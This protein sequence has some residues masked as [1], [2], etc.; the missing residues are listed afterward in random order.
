MSIEDWLSIDVKTCS[1]QELVLLI[2]QL[3][4]SEH[5]ALRMEIQRELINRLRF[6]GESD[7]R[8]IEILL[9]G[10][11]VGAKRDKIAAGWAEAFGLTAREFKRIARGN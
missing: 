10:V 1:P 2:E 3:E 7:A 6:K 9:R 4:G 5:K 8:I 11:S